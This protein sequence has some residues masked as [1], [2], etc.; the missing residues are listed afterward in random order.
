MTP[1]EREKAKTYAERYGTSDVVAKSLIAALAALH[2]AET[3]LQQPV[4]CYRPVP[5]PCGPG[6][7]VCSPT[8]CGSCVGCCLK[9]R[10]AKTESAAQNELDLGTLLAIRL[11][12]S[13]KYEVAGKCCWCDSRVDGFENL[14][15]DTDH[16]EDCIDNLGALACWYAARGYENKVKAKP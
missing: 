4:R 6:T 3:L 16:D 5:C 9:E 1:E 8:D 2:T 12:Q 10:I 11:A 7:H 14:R 15:I 13:S